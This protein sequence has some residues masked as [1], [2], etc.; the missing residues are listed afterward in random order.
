MKK[1]VL[2]FFLLPLI[3]WAQHSIQGTFTPAES[4]NFAL[5][6]HV[7]PTGANYISQSKTTETGGWT[8]SLDENAQV[9]IYKV[10]YA[11][12]IEA[13]NFDLFYNGKED[14]TLTYDLEKGLQILQS[15]E[16]D[17]W[18]TYSDSI[19]SLNGLVS[20]L[21]SKEKPNEA[22]ITEV[23]KTL[24]NTQKDFEAET[25]D[26]MIAPF[27]KSNRTYI[28]KT[29]ESLNT[30]AS[31]LKAHYFD[32]IAFENK[33]L[34]ISDFLNERV[35][36]YVFAMPEQPKYY[37]NAV[38][39][40]VT[41]IGNNSEVKIIVLENLWHQMIAQQQPEV[42]NYI[43]DT[44]LLP[45]A[46]MRNKTYLVNTLESYNKSAVGKRAL[47]FEFTYLDN[48][49]AVQTDLYH[50]NT[51]SKTLLIFWSSGCSHCL[52]EL[53]KV[54]TLMEKHP[55]IKVLAYALEDG[56]RSWNQTIPKFPNFTHTYDLKK[57]DSPLIKEYGI[58]ATPSFFILDTNKTILA[59]P[60]HVSDL[61][62]YFNQ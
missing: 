13:N 54:K 21:Y 12:P 15:A 14:I 43:S 31:N 5:L 19:Q 58:S 33:L 60:D 52:E 7:T 29:Y 61:E 20:K 2:L 62:T 8:F 41:A 36:A 44:Y 34:Q 23:F 32:Y 17:I 24:S 38:D 22:Q 46:K 3:T 51:T 1:L 47:N 18:Q 39:D 59:K 48:K 4:F 30:Y 27:V 42:A 28:P 25:A 37:M 53:P 40:V 57:W 16:N 50:F 26:M 9:G 11:V 10:V 55:D 49:K 56:V 45:L 35:E 6:Y